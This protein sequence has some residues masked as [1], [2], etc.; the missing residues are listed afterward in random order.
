MYGNYDFRNTHAAIKERVSEIKT[1]AKTNEMQAR[2][3][4]RAL[5]WEFVELVAK[6]ASYPFKELAVE[7]EQL[8][9]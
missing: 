1:T 8:N 9:R 6:R 7:L 2:A 3:D 4:E 5:L